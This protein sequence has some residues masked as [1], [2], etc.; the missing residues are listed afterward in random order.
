V[1]DAAA[2]QDVPMLP[3]PLVKICDFGYSK[4]E[5]KSAA[6][7]KVSQQGRHKVLPA[8]AAAAATYICQHCDA[9]ATRATCAAC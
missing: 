8:A 1:S 7:S 2:V 9:C 5:N 6:K 3:L 4:A